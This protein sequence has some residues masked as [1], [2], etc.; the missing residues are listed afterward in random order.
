MFSHRLSPSAKPTPWY[1]GGCHTVLG[2]ALGCGRSQGVLLDAGIWA[3]RGLSVL[4]TPSC[5][6][7]E[8]QSW[9]VI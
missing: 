9:R 4:V 1:L 5:K 3:S 2:A 8:A 6:A 7:V